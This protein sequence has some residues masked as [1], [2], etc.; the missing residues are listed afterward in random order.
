MR[1]ILP[2]VLTALAVVLLPQW[3]AAEEGKRPDGP[4]PEM[5]HQ[6]P[7]PEVMFKRLDAN[8]DGIITP[9]EI[10]AGMPEPLKQLLKRA[11]R[12]GDKKVT[13]AELTEA[14]KHRPPGPP[15]SGPPGQPAHRDGPRPEGRLMPGQSWHQPAGREGRPSPKP[16]VASD[17][18]HGAPDLKCL[19]ARIDRDKDG[20]L[21]YD[22][23]AV[24]MKGLQHVLA[25]RIQRALWLPVY[26]EG[27]KSK[28]HCHSRHH[29]HHSD[30]AGKQPGKKP[31]TSP[32]A[33]T[34]TCP[35]AKAGVHPSAKK[36]ACPMAKKTDSTAPA[37]KK[38]VVKVEVKVSVE[39]KAIEAKLISLEKEKAATIDSLQKAQQAAAAKIRAL[40]KQRAEVLGSMQKAKAAEPKK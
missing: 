17:R 40:D 21:S 32:S 18:P 11:D 19:F 3:V 30:V 14:M 2:S 8:H 10:S 5:R 1:R 27:M 23:F 25:M 20:K 16:P 34:G 22:E 13:L 12:N 15:R 31:A 29:A 35:V 9:D 38:P 4:R 28:H 6:R 39:K 36:G 33:K 37:A 26:P 7:N 24:G